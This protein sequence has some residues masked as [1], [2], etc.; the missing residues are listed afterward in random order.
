[1]GLNPGRLGMT[2]D[3]M[4][5]WTKKNDEEVYSGAGEQ[6]GSQA[7]YWREVEMKRRQFLLDKE[8]AAASIEASVMQVAAAKATIETAFWTKV[9]G[10]AVAVTVVITGISL[11]L[12]A[13][14]AVK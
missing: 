12:Q 13:L 10:I 11:V 5:N 6:P 4:G 14:P 7:S 8:V 9:S 3:W 2:D 1:M